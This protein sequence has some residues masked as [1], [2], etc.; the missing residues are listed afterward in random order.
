MKA[1]QLIGLGALM[2]VGGLVLTAGTWLYAAV[3][4]NSGKYFV[5]TGLMLWGGINIVR[6][7]VALPKYQK[8]KAQLPAAI[9]AGIQS[10]NPAER[11]QVANAL[12]HYADMVPADLLWRVVVVGMADP[13]ADVRNDMYQAL[14]SLARSKHDYARLLLRILVNQADQDAR[15]MK[16]WPDAPSTLARLRLLVTNDAAYQQW[17]QTGSLPSLPPAVAVP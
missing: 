1:P 3:G 7:L 10:N 2:V 17:R 16:H 6:G 5:F 15:V 12:P 4:Q 13:V 9:S 11:Q 8:A 14:V